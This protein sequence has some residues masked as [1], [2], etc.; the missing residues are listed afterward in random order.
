MNKIEL[1]SSTKGIVVTV[2]L[3]IFPVT[4]MMLLFLNGGLT[5][6]FAIPFGATTKSEVTTISSLV[7]NSVLAIS[8]LIVFYFA[9]RTWVTIVSTFLIMF[10]GQMLVMFITDEFNGGDNY[11]LGW[12]TVSGIPT[13]TI[14]TIGLVKYFMNDRQLERVR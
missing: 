14:L 2:A 5:Y 6:I 11:L 8:G 13:L 10:S 9:R 1:S 3:T 4:Q 7:V 12:L